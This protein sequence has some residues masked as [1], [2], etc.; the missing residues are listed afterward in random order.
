[1]RTLRGWRAWA[2]FISGVALISIADNYDS[3][4]WHI[5]LGVGVMLVFDAGWS[6]RNYALRNRIWLPS[7]KDSM[8]DTNARGERC[9]VRCVGHCARQVGHPGRHTAV[10]AE[11]VS[12]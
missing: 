2:L 9:N 6:A 12:S 5:V 8:S 4:L 7:L 11:E 10:V 1:M 3:F